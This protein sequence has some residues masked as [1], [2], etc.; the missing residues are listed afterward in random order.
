MDQQTRFINGFLTAIEYNKDKVRPID[1]NHFSYSRKF[2]TPYEGAIAE[3]VQEMFIYDSKNTI[4]FSVR[5]GNYQ[6]TF[7]NLTRYTPAISKPDFNGV[8]SIAI[9]NVHNYQKEEKTTADYRLMAENI[10]IDMEKQFK[11]KSNYIEAACMRIINLSK[12]FELCEYTNGNLRILENKYFVIDIPSNEWL[13]ISI[14]YMIKKDKKCIKV[15]ESF[16]MY[17][18]F[19]KEIENPSDKD[20]KG[21]LENT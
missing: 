3:T 14:E 16:K 15:N 10:L 6:D 13:P 4:V 1:T 9:E 12:I 21:I 7:V 17:P 5:E 8:I 11:E 19:L 2:I 18:S 20:I